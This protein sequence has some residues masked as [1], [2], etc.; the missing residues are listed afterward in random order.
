MNNS[1]ILFICIKDYSLQG[2]EKR[3]IVFL[4]LGQERK[5]VTHDNI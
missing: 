5:E 3:C 2:K 4:F 1:T